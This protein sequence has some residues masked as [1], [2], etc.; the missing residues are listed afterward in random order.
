MSYRIRVSFI[1]KAFS[2]GDQIWKDRLKKYFP[3]I[4]VENVFN[5]EF[6]KNISRSANQS[7]VVI[8]F[9]E[10]QSCLIV[11]P[12]YECKIEKNQDGNDCIIFVE[13]KFLNVYIDVDEKIVRECYDLAC[14][15]WKKRIE[16]HIPDFKSCIHKI[17]NRYSIKTSWDEKA[18]YILAR[19]TFDKV[20]LISLKDGN[21]WAEPVEVRDATNLTSQEF[22]G[23]CGTRHPS[24]VTLIS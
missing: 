1:E 21:R 11:L 15:E 4:F 24:E 17:G 22:A 19:I 8:G 5:W 7:P 3:E 2:E 14:T 10:A 23:V 12:E 16:D 6:G 13:K 18:E 20:A 9:H